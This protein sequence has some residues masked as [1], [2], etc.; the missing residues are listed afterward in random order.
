MKPGTGLAAASA[1]VAGAGA[2][3]WLCMSSYSQALGPFPYRG[4]PDRKVVALSFTTGRTSLT[5]HSSRTSS[6]TGA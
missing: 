3:Y 2:A 4:A 1:L 5:P 6:A